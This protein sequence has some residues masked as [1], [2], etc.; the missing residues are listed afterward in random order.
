MAR[1]GTFI[2]TKDNGK[3]KIYDRA[4]MDAVIAEYGDGEDLQLHIEEVGRKRTQ[5]QNRYF[6]S[7]VLKGF[8]ALGYRSQEAKEMLCLRFIPQEV[9]QLDG[10][11]VLVPG[12]TS[13]LKVEEFNDFIDA[14]IQLAAENDV[15]IEDAAEWRAQRQPKNGQ[16][17]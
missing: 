14:C 13:E 15:V 7:A 17:A 6:H 4:G 1:T 8:A 9:R 16:A 11:V 5:K 10:T 3:L 12:H 2:C